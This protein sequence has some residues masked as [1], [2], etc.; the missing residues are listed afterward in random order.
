MSQCDLGNS[1]LRFATQV[2]L[3]CVRL[4]DKI[5][6]CYLE[7]E[8]KKKERDRQRQGEEYFSVMPL[9]DL[10]PSARFHLKFLEPS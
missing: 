8:E 7:V 4:T 10:L 5:N 6:Q 9:G 2:T 1:S 3:D